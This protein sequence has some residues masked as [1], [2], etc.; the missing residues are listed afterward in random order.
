MLYTANS[1][2][3]SAG[4]EEG[5]MA[6]DAG[7]LDTFPELLMHH[8]RVR[9]ARPA[10]REKDLGIWQTWTWQQYADE[11]RAL[12]CGLAAQGFRRGV[13]LALVGDIRPRRYAS[14]CAAQFLGGGTVYWCR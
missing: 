5:S 9:G 3:E 14:I 12:A 1:V 11:V 13:P 8:A 2:Q 7:T 10:I 6:M 4:S